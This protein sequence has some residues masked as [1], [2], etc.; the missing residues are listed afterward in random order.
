MIY[1]SIYIIS[2]RGY[3]VIWVGGLAFLKI[4]IFYN[5][6]L[7]LLGNYISFLNLGAKDLNYA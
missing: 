6:K 2:H 4:I 3:V 1:V 7:K 5:L